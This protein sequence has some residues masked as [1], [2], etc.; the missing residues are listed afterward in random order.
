MKGFSLFEMVLVIGMSI[1]ISGLIFSILINNNGVLY[2]QNSVISEGLSLND[3]IS[4]IDDKIRQATGVAV[5]Y[6]EVSPS[7]FSSAT[8]LVLKLPALDSQGVVNNV[9]DYMVITQ[10]SP[11][12]KI[13]RLQVFPDPLSNR[14]AEDKVL[15]TLVENIQFSFLDKAG[16]SVTPEAAFQVGVNL[17]VL[18]KT[19]T[20]GSN[21]SASSLT[22]LRNKSI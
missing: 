12:N 22:T 13:L 19:G 18:S 7:Y 15:T 21:R 1:L 5:G 16:A 11:N 3:T 4:A 2:K 14:K 17:S 9:Y 20:I 6:P 10:D 8:T